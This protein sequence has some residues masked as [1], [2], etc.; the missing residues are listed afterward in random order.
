ML[1]AL[2]DASAKGRTDRR[3]YSN[4]ELCAGAG[5][6]AV[7]LSR[8]GF[9]PASIVEIDKRACETLRTNGS[10]YGSRGQGW[11]VEQGDITRM[12]FSDFLGVD[13]LSAGAPCQ[14][15]S[16]G[17]RLR[18]T[19]D[20]RNLFP[21]VIRAIRESKPRAFMLENVR[22]LLFPRARPYF[23]Y[24]LSHLANPSVEFADDDSW[25][26]AHTFLGLIP[27][28]E[29]E[30]R[31]SWRLLNAADY[32]LAQ[33]RVRLVIVAFRS[34]VDAGTWDWPAPTHSKES[35]VSALHAD[36]YWNEFGV[37]ARI[38]R[39]VREALPTMSLDGADLA[40]WNTLR[41][42]L[43]TYGPPTVEDAGD[44]HFF[45]PGAKLYRKHNGSSLDWTS[46][47][48]KAGVNGS[49]GGEHIVHLD[50]GT[51]RYLTV[52]ECAALQGFPDDYWFP[53]QRR[54]AMRLIGNAVP[55]GVAEAVGKTIRAV[56]AAQK[57]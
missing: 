42:L 10:Q 21:D 49:P 50:D 39:N 20:H 52:R 11:P 30:Y 23:D 22:G 14:P 15:F 43:A 40:P 37:G 6:L 19:N 12:S 28:E 36:E 48:V 32:G 56:L 57:L 1:S 13:L 41:R 24:L 33:L 53:E 17:G 7:G 8:A 46:K 51:F 35:L 54:P 29:A 47:T 38:R 3:I 5:G 18:G 26:D 9:T 31:V 34:D 55:V 25:A 2:R 16:I 45:V 27:A 44:R 4:L